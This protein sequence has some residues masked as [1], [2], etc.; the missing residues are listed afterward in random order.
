MY[1]YLIG[2]QKMHYSLDDSLCWKVLVRYDVPA[3]LIS[4]IR[5]FHD[6]T[7]ACVRLDSSD[8]SEVVV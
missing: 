4:I 7:P 8:T 1:V 2:L 5:Q 6:G 3:K